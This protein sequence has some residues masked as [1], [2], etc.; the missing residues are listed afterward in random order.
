MQAAAPGWRPC[1]APHCGATE[2]GLKPPC[3][4]PTV[5]GP[6]TSLGGAWRPA[7]RTSEAEIADAIAQF[8][9]RLKWSFLKTEV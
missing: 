8:I 2:L 9:Y 4:E 3:H 7:M 1:H 6:E 5:V